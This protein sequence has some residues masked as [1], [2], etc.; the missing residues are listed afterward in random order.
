MKQRIKENNDIV[1]KGFKYV[2]INAGTVTPINNEVYDISLQKD[3]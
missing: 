1:G 2:S 3:K